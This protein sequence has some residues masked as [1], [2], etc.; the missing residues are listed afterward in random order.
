M[1]LDIA[2]DPVLAARRAPRLLRRALACALTVL[3]L[4]AQTAHAQQEPEAIV[5]DATKRILKLIDENLKTYQEDPAVFRAVVERTLAPHFDFERMSKLV[6]GN[7]EWKK[8]DAAM[9]GAF[10]EQF[11][12]LLVRSY[13]SI[14]L[15]YRGQDISFPNPI[16]F[17][18]DK[19]RVARVRARIKHGAASVGYYFVDFVF[20]RTPERWGVVDVS[21][22]G[23][24]LVTT[25]SANF[26]AIVEQRGMDAL[27]GDLRK[28]N[29]AAARE[30]RP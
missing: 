27:N 14:L 15:N 25:Y 23:V 10:I 7:D 19:K 29:E 12:T 26:K 5:R 20:L 1:D 28:L 13:G 24:S 9:Q 30:T 21:I 11:R 2:A 16:E 22:D 3:A 4:G 17:L 6:L 18:D 8:A